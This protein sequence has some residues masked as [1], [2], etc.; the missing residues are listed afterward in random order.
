M[1]R[2]RDDER[3]ACADDLACLAQD[4]LETARVDVA[5]EL[6]CALGRLDAV[7]LDDTTLDL[8]DRLLRDDE[9]R[10]RCSTPA[11]AN[12]S[13]DEERAEVVS[14]LELRDSP[15]RDDAELA[16]QPRPVTRIPACPL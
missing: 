1:A 7:E 5:G 6:A 13:L 2:L 15:K 4:D 16:G 10:R 8:R 11:G 14:V 9:R 12:R 3:R